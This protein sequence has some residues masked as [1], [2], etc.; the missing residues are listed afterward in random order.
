MRQK[1]WPFFLA[2]QRALKQRDAMTPDGVVHQARLAVESGQF[3]RFPHV[4]VDEIQDFGL[5]ALR[6]IRS[7]TPLDGTRDPLCVV[8][9]GQQRIYVAPLAQSRAGID[10][11]GRS[12]RLKVNYRTSEQIRR[13]AQGILQGLDVDDL[14]GQ[15]ASTVGDRSAFTGPDPMVEHCTS[16]EQEASQVAAWV[17]LLLS[18]GLKPEEICVTPY[19][20]DVRQALSTACIPTHELKPGEPDPGPNT[21]AVRLG[22]MPRIKGLEF[23]AVA[24]C[25]DAGPEISD[26]GDWARTRCQ[27]YVAAT[28][29][30]EHLLVTYA[31]PA[32][33]P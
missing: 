13:W 32:A 21:A 31:A 11:R 8:G 15:P 9:D 19:R 20:P 14:D 1:A 4:L 23:R 29:A 26:A 27:Q 28:R 17:K 12:R 25:L 33:Y 10:V 22:A 30:R 2:F 6:L 5:E 24:M 16:P 7:L 18:Q 3:Q